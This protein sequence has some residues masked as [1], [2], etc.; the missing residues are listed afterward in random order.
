MS[1]DKDIELQIRKQSMKRS[2]QLTQMGAPGA[3][4]SQSRNFSIMQEDELSL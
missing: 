4:M 1:T 3:P 2:G